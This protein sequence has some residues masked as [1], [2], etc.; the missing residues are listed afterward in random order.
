MGGIG[1]IF[2]KNAEFF[3]GIDNH[4]YLKSE[5]DLFNTFNNKKMKF[6]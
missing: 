6:F 3:N 5:Y 1:D 4:Y 2:V